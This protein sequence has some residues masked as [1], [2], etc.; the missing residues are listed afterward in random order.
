MPK[1]DMQFPGNAKAM[2]PPTA[3]IGP[4]ACCLFIPIA[5]YLSSSDVVTVL[6][7]TQNGFP[8]RTLVLIAGIMTNESQTGLSKQWFYKTRQEALQ[9]FFSLFVIIWQVMCYTCHHLIWLHTRL[10]I[11]RIFFQSSLLGDYPGYE[12]NIQGDNNWK[13]AMTCYS[14]LLNYASIHFTFFYSTKE[15]SEIVELIVSGMWSI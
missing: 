13:G 6:S 15:N 2:P 9:P 4:P 12:L 5:F 10:Q 3:V 8:A 7:S 14:C 1:F 11:Y